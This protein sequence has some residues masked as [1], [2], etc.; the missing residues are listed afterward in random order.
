MPVLKEEAILY[1]SFSSFDK[2][3]YNLENLSSYKQLEE[4]GFYR[5]VK[6]PQKRLFD[7]NRPINSIK[8]FLH[9]NNLVLRY[10]IKKYSEDFP[11]KEYEFYSHLPEH[12]YAF[13]DVRACDLRAISILD[14]VFLNK[15]S[16]KDPFYK[17]LRENIF[18]VLI[19]CSSNLNTCFCFS[20]GIDP[21]KENNCDMALLE[22]EDSI[23]VE[24]FTQKASSLLKNIEKDG[25]YKEEDFFEEKQLIYNKLKSTQIRKVEGLEN[26]KEK[27]YQNLEHEFWEEEGKR[28][29]ACTACTNV[30]P[31]CFCF[32]IKREISPD[33]KL[34]KEVR[35]RDSC[36]NQ[37]FASLHKFNLRESIK[38]RHRQ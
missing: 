11:K 20:L 13:F 14:D 34:S 33:L 6:N 8:D 35:I 38:S 1:D 25:P 23:L 24:S 28:C 3:P 36:Y 2:L 10:D 31:T 32:D 18:V 16:H 19:R 15:N 5:I 17:A 21:F 30:C 22:L 4:S 37:S 12:K 29:I 9:P 27:I 7:Y 26:I